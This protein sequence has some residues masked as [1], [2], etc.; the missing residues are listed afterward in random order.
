VISLWSAFYGLFGLVGAVILT[1]TIGLV[2]AALSGAAWYFEEKRTALPA[3]ILSS[4][5][6]CSNCGH[7][8]NVHYLINY[9][10]EMFD[11]GE[12][13]CTGNDCTC[14]S[15]WNAEITQVPAEREDSS[16]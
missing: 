11:G 1:V 10:G 14:K 7:E 8:F 6:R 16:W 2:V 15:R 12:M 13:I 3:K 5:A 4:G 9:S